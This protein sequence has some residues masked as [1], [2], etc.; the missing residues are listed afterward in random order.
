[1]K[2][3]TI[4]AENF[5][6]FETLKIENLG[7]INSFIGKNSSGKSNITQLLRIFFDLLEN[8]AQNTAISLS[9]ELYHL[10]DTDNPIKISLILELSE[11]EKETL[12]IKKLHQTAELSKS[13]KQ[14][15]KES[16]KSQ[17]EY[18]TISIELGFVT[19][20]KLTD[21][22]FGSS[23][24]DVSKFEDI[25]INLVKKLQYIPITR[26]QIEDTNVYKRN[27]II[28][29]ELFAE[30]V[31]LESSV[32]D[33]KLDRKRKKLIS[34]LKGTSS[35]S[36]FIT[37]IGD[38]IY[39]DLEVGRISI[40]EIGGGDQEF[41]QMILNIM[42]PGFSFIIIEE[43][44]VHL[45]NELQRQLYNVLEIFSKDKQFFI[46]THSTV[47]ID[48]AKLKNTYLVLH[49]GI[50]SE[51]KNLSDKE[52]LKEI[53]QILGIRPS[54]IFQAEKILFVE[55]NSDRIFFNKVSE[56][57]NMPFFKNDVGIIPLGGVGKGKR[58]LALF[59]EI[60]KINE[61]PKFFIL[62]KGTQKEAEDLEK[63][64]STVEYHVLKIGELED[65]YPDG[66]ILDGL[67]A[68]YEFE[69]T[70]DEKGNFKDKL[71]KSKKKCNTIIQILRNKGIL[72]DE[73]MDD[74]NKVY[75]WKFQLAKYV[76][77][78]IKKSEIRDEI[79]KA[80]KNVNLILR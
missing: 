43:P 9:P 59:N 25:R 60:T 70:S 64:D 24:I 30:L 36:Q 75:G 61:I 39:M 26:N 14:K 42:K 50:K 72:K 51:I 47:F 33:N 77:E 1:M 4:E 8:F 3:R 68:I 35:I 45:H 73:D 40:G 44:E 57:L 17:K 21:L 67:K 32:D 58:Y 38:K 65:Y 6:S 18:L 31:K 52:D 2:I 76:G 46:T 23:A 29:K 53:L 79:K 27:S 28:L 62:D 80:I 20:W 78:N 16:D 7:N 48:K 10:K 49:D 74:K 54:D 12:K 5:K 37:G 41:I 66:L 63:S 34:I 71:S 15:G 55:G 56:K 19:G 11:K 22:N 69:Y 13:G